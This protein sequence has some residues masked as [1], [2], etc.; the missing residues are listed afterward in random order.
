MN[1]MKNCK[2]ADTGED[3]ALDANEPKQ[4][5]EKDNDS[6]DMKRQDGTETLS[7]GI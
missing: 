2:S 7:G 4:G 1:R 3:E 6:K 5:K